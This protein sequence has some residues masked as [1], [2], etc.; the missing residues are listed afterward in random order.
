M[1][2][3]EIHCP[4]CGAANPA[5]STGCRVCNFPFTGVPAPPA[6]AEAPASAEAS[7]PEAAEPS[8]VVSAEEPIAI[9]MPPRLRRM[10]EQRQVKD[11]SLTLW[12][13]VGVLGAIAL[14]YIAVRA[15]VERAFPPVEGAQPEQQTRAN[16]LVQAIE[17][18]ST[19][20][21]ARVAFGDVLYDTGN[22][23]EAIVHYRAALRMD[24]TRVESLVDLGVCYYNLGFTEEA[25]RHFEMALAKNPLQTVA[26][27]NMGI[28]SERLENHE[29]AL[30]FYHRSLQTE[31]PEPMRAPI[32]EAIGRVQQ[33][34]GRAAPPLPEG[35]LPQG[36]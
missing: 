15:N 10:R 4:D 13:I 30:Q 29:A 23:S 27:F 18:D 5:G 1:D 17:Q 8:P 28:L 9:E 31:P 32:V 26:L 12:L 25:R 24:S 21:D 14:I 11:P 16:E 19:N 34:L 7:A 2:A 33:K 36:R 3:P 20:V 22:W 35:A 6:P